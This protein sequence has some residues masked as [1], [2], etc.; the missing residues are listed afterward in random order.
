MVLA[1]RSEKAGYD[2]LILGARPRVGGRNWSLRDGD[3][4][5]QFASTQRI[6]WDR[7]PHLYFNPG[8][9]RLPY[10]HQ[11]ILSYCRELNVPLE[12][13]CNDDRAAL[14]QDDAAFNGTPQLNRRVV[15][16]SRG[17]VAELAAKAVGMDETL[18]AEDA[19]RLKAFIRTYGG[20]ST[21]LRY[22]GSSRAGWATPPATEPG[23]YNQPLPFAEIL[24]ADF[25]KGP[26]EFGDLADM[27]PTMVQPV[28]GMG[29]IGQAFYRRLQRRIRLNA[30]VTEIRRT[31]TAARIVWKGTRTGR[32]V[33][34]MASTVVITIPLT[35]LR[36]IPADFS[37]AVQAAIAAPSYVPAGKVAFQAERRFWEQDR[38]I[39]GGISWT[40][41]DITQIWYLT[42]G[43]QQRKGILVGAYIWSQDIGDRFAALPPDHRLQNALADGEHLHPDYGRSLRNGVSIAWKNVPFTQG[44]WA[45]WTRADR[46]AHYETLLRGEGPF[47]FAGEHLSYITGWQEGAVQSAHAALKRI[48]GSA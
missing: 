33:E 12:V 47:L 6:A 4:I 9:A 42:A 40:S 16:D 29:R 17:Y 10:H 28:G 38:Q 25:W 36:S 24:R 1:L 30:Q 23:T 2:P 35:V 32:S 39:Y 48:G 21:D 44:A 8:P 7:A 31:P 22:H 14:M 15:E 3:M 27:A 46:D 5:R 34:E 18:S 13:M 11:G 41:R 20:L 37:S 19:H 45:D 26:P 43:L